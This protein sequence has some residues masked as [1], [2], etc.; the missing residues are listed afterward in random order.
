MSPYRESLAEFLVN[1]EPSLELI[2]RDERAKG[3]GPVVRTQFDS[4][5]EPIQIYTTALLRTPTAR[6]IVV[7]SV[8]NIAESQAPPPLVT[9]ISLKSA[10]RWLRTNGFP[11]PE[12]FGEFR[13]GE[14]NESVDL[15]EETGFVATGGLARMIR[16]S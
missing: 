15:T 1:A 6:W 7:R 11:V 2:L 16:C 14:D 8:V 13:C 3:W 10:I 12:E 9:H 4:C 5:S